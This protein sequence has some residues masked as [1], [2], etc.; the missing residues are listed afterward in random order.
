MKEEA[1][2]V[3]VMVVNLGN[4]IIAEIANNIELTQD[5]LSN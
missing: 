4:H 3:D 1:P 5:L 2:K